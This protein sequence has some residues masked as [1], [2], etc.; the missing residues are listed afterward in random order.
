MRL[1]TGLPA[2]EFYDGSGLLFVHMF[3]T[4]EARAQA[5]RK[6][7]GPATQNLDHRYRL[8]SDDR[9]YVASLGADPD[10]LLADMNAHRIY[11]ADRG[12][13]RYM[14]R[15]GGLTGA[16]EKPVLTIHAIHDGLATSRPRRDGVRLGRPG[17]G[18][19][20]PHLHPQRHE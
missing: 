14:Q 17:H 7:G 6:M 16:L 1:V 3:F 10:A 15:F 12:A 19:E 13:R 9:T 2:E 4:T 20:R 8:S 5:E 11:A 18:R